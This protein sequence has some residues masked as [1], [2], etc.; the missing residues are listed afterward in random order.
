MQLS[1][2]LRRALAVQ[3]RSP[4]ENALGLLLSWTLLGV[5]NALLV[6]IYIAVPAGGW[7][8]R[9]THLAGELGAHLLLGGLTAGAA[10]IHSRIGRCSGGRAAGLF[11]L[12]HVPLC[13]W[14][15]RD[16]F[17]QLA[18]RMS[19]ATGLFPAAAIL[20]PVLG[21]CTFLLVV[22][23]LPRRLPPGW[24]Q[25]VAVG[26]AAV[27]YELNINV[28]RNDNRGA[29][30]LLSW[31]SVLLISPVLGA[32]AVRRLS[33]HFRRSVVAVLVM[34]LPVGGATALV[35]PSN[36]VLIDMSQWPATIIPTMRSRGRLEPID[37]GDLD[38]GQL[39]EF[40][41]E[42]SAAPP[43]PPTKERLLPARRGI[44]LLITIDGLRADVV[45]DPAY[46][47][48]VPNI[49]QMAAEGT[50]FVNAR[51]PG[52]Q[53]V[54][55]LSALSTGKYFSQLYWSEY[56][57][58]IWPHAD[59]SVHF[60]MLLDHHGVTTIL[61]PGA[62]WFDG[63]Y[64]VLRGFRRGRFPREQESWVPGTDLTDRL[65]RALEKHRRR[66]LFMYV[67]YLDS[68]APYDVVDVGTPFERYLAEIQMVDREV[69][70]IVEK[71]REL[72]LEK[73]AMVV[74][75]SD[76][77]EAFGE[78]GAYFH[79][80]N[81]YE[82][83]IRVPLIVWGAGITARKVEEPVSLV[84]LGPTILDLFDIATPGTFMGESLVPLL[85]GGER[86]F[87]RPIVAE[88]RLMRA[89]VFPDG[90]KVV[91]DARS[92]LVEA[93]DLNLDPRETTNLSDLDD[94]IAKAHVRELI[95]FFEIHRL[96]RD[97]YE[98]PYRK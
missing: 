30:L 60:P 2:H 27:V 4:A 20:V 98:P 26:L 8:V 81:L 77:G 6:V 78:H 17:S 19:A 44:V 86:M 55:T 46:A 71:I 69:G 63:D 11:W 50:T 66:Q 31:S 82:E 90:Y 24:P 57:G 70:R 32:V 37:I 88:T 91:W 68:H 29:H 93:Y 39:G 1:R 73:R 15:L 51:A 18:A 28:S 49:R 95:A 12:I 7:A 64:G 3:P 96:K 94:P 16:D 41:V 40:F 25:A 80:S 75:S 21:F 14:L 83:L 34:L 33:L 65:V 67:H 59:S 85:A 79:S 84:D 5:C 10:W 45:S 35:R 42:R 22:W 61:V 47:E 87:S 74:V 23:W 56:R 48:Y 97:G 43:V 36:S 54:Y 38:T 9:G 76:H 13:F 58:A 72:G 62:K 53:T 92:G 52:S 89:M